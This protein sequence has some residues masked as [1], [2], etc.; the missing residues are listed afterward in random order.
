MVGC[1][2]GNSW[3][4]SAAGVRPPVARQAV[5]LLRSQRTAV[6]IAQGSLRAAEVTHGFDPGLLPA[7]AEVG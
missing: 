6:Q 4:T 3:W 2:S 5:L 7:V 1:G